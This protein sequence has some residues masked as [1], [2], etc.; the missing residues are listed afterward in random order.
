MKNYLVNILAINYSLLKDSTGSNLAALLAGNSPARTLI[1]ILNVNPK[2]AYDFFIKTKLIPNNLI[3][4]IF[5]PFI[6]AYAKAS[7][8]IPLKQPIKNASKTKIFLISFRRPPMAL[9]MPISL[10]R[11]TTLI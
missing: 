9:I 1:T 10:V 3:D 4:L 7:P 8:I 6:N 11:S 2:A 5:I